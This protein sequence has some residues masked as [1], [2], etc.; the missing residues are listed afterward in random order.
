M[1]NKENKEIIEHISEDVIKIVDNII[2][3]SIEAKASDVHFEPQES[4]MITRFRIDGSMN[5]FYE[6]DLKLYK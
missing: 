6:C 1:L 5:S 4:K 3:A 2:K